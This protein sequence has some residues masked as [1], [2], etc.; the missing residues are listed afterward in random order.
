MKEK[1]NITIYIYIQ[2]KRDI[3]FFRPIAMF[4]VT[5]NILQ[6]ISHIQPGCEEYFVDHSQSQR[7]LLGV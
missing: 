2:M 7:T 1:R 6:N 3:T 5:D 4:C